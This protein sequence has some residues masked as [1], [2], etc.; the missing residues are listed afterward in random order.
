MH[1][2][3]G[4]CFYCKVETRLSDVKIKRQKLIPNETKAKMKSESAISVTF[5]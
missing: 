1:L 3:L 2:V 4:V 5:P